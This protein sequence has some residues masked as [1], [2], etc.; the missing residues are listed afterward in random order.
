M[1]KRCEKHD[2][3]F[4]KLIRIDENVDKVKK[5]MSTINKIAITVFIFCITG[6]IGYLATKATQR[7]EAKQNAAIQQRI[8]K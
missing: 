2:E 6:S 4:E 8:N 7:A 5:Y 1:D 3:M